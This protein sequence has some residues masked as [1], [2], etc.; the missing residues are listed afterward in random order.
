MRTSLSGPSEI[1]VSSFNVI[2]TVPPAAVRRVSLA[3]TASPGLA[4]RVAFWRT[5][6]AEPETVL[7]CPAGVTCW[8]DTGVT[9]AR[10]IART[11]PN[12]WRPL[13]RSSQR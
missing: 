5:T 4:A 2:P 10:T 7:M 1:R 9:A 6:Y 13:I 12:R 11:P 3:K 8:A